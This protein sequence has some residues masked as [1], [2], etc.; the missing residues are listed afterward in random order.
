MLPLLVA[1]VI[2]VLL[3]IPADRAASDYFA[4]YRTLDG[5]LL[6]AAAAVE[7][8]NPEGIV[9]VRRDWRN[10]PIGWWFEGLTTAEI[11]VGSDPRWLGFPDEVRRAELV[12]RFFTA[13]LDAD[14]LRDLANETGVELLALRKWEWIGWQRWLEGPDPAVEPIYDDNEFLVLRILHR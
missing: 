12:D 14:Q 11:A 4:Y 1:L 8:A 7:A 5:P 2:P 9:A 13:R 6:G 3:V 10:W